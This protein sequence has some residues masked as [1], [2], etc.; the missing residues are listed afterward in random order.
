MVRKE[1][2]NKDTSNRR[3]G[4]IYVEGMRE[5]RTENIVVQ[6][7]GSSR[8]LENTARGSS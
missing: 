2:R 3:N 8:R 7:R 6:E 1:E 5:E 4:R